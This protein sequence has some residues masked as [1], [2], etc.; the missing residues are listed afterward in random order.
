MTAATEH[1]IL[2]GG[3]FWGMQDLIRR[4]PG[5]ISTRVGYTGGEVPNA[6]Y[7]NHGI[8]CRGYRDRV[9]SADHQLS[10][11]CSSSSSRFTTRR[12]AIARATTWSEL[13]FGD[14]L[15]ERRAEAGGRRHHRRR[16]CLGAVAGQG[17]DRSDA[18]QRLLAG[19]ARA[20]GLSGARARTATRAISS[21]RTG[22][23]RAV[24]TPARCR[25]RPFIATAHLRQ[26]LQL[27]RFV[28]TNSLVNSNVQVGPTE[29][30]GCA[31]YRECAEDARVRRM[32]LRDFAQ[33]IA[34]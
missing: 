29:A 26:T 16:Q 19:R 18:G 14:L 25:P 7:R 11:T 20:S 9:R 33:D 24:P 4:M 1:A 27:E 28:G 31:A 34:R 5:V 21:G 22:S 12:R 13:S 30:V 8:A 2:A 17:G 3:C 6:T 23:S 15:Y 32:R 10:Q